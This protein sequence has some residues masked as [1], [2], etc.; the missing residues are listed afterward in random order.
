MS[1]SMHES[2]LIT[3]SVCMLRLN[4]LVPCHCLVFVT[5]L[6]QFNPTMSLDRYYYVTITV[7]RLDM[8][9]YCAYRILTSNVYIS[10]NEDTG[11]VTYN[12]GIIPCYLTAIG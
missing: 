8:L 6:G 1:I 5:M 2:T 10:V 4:L 9:C 11:G 3:Y 12:Q 7:Q